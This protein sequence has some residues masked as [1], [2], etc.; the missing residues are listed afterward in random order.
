MIDRSGPV[1]KVTEGSSMDGESKA[2]LSQARR[3]E[4]EFES[5]FSLDRLLTFGL[6]TRNR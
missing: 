1:M 6:Q 4:F 3:G 2:E 5:L